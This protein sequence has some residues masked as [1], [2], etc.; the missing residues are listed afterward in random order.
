[1]REYK[2]IIS[3]KTMRECCYCSCLTKFVSLS[4][5][6]PICS[7]KCEDQLTIEYYKTQN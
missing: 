7:V 6:A 3:S 2:G 5:E 4:F 1:M